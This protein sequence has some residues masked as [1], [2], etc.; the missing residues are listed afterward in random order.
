MFY[1]KTENFRGIRLSK[2]HADI[3]VV[4]IFIKSINLCLSIGRAY[5]QL[6][7]SIFQVNSK[8]YS[9]R[10]KA[11]TRSVNVMYCTELSNRQEFSETFPVGAKL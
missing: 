10:D 6:A 1:L 7:V 9:T 5:W 2:M 4:F 8:T 11:R 3:N